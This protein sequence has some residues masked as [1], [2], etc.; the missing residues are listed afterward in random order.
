MCTENVT[1]TFIV[2]EILKHIIGLIK[3][4]VDHDHGDDDC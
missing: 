1:K 4:D 3:T 2:L